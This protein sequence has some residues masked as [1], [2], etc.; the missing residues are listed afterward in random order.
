MR[1]T[2]LSALLLIPA[3]AWIDQQ[4]YERLEQD[5]EACDE[6]GLVYYPD[7]DGDGFGDATSPTTC[8][9]GAGYLTDGSDCDDGDPQVH[10]GAEEYCN[11]V[12]DDCDGQLDEDEAV[13]A[14]RWYQDQDG[15]GHAD[16]DTWTMAC[17]QP[18]GFL[19]SEDADDCDDHDATVNPEAD[20]ICGDG[21]DNDCDDAPEVGGCRLQGA[22]RWDAGQ[23]RLYAAVDEEGLGRAA[24][25]G[26]DLIGSHGT[27]L[28][29]GVQSWDGQATDGGGVLLFSGEGLA[30]AVPI[31]EHD[32]VLAGAT[33]GLAAGFRVAAMGEN[34]ADG[35]PWLAVTCAPDDGSLGAVLFLRGPFLE[36]SAD[37]EAEASGRMNASEALDELGASSSGGLDATGDGL[38]EL[39]LGAPG[40]NSGA[41]EAYLLHGPVVS[42]ESSDT[43]EGRIEGSEPGDRLGES[44]ALLPDV[45]GDGLADL[46]IGAST[47]GDAREG[48]V[49]LFLSPLAAG[50]Q[51]SDAEERYE[52]E[53]SGAMLHRVAAAGDVDGDGR[54]DMLLGAPGAGDNQ[55]GQVFLL[56]GATNPP[57]TLAHP[58]A[59]ILGSESG[60]ALGMALAGLEDFDGDGRGDILV[61]APLFDGDGMDAGEAFLF[62]GPVQGSLET[63]DADASVLGPGGSA[64]AGSLLGDAGD[65]DGDGLSDA[66]IGAPFGG[67]Q[68]IVLF[69]GQGW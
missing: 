35:S 9:Q 36:D 45:D 32:V 57:A 66:F 42:I 65:L 12:D 49:L 68:Q 67:F 16:P 47:A 1:T 14:V 48:E 13:D 30:G 7:E 20:E 22:K 53:Q 21:I 63:R 23:A 10:P 24:A 3:C 34:N 25:G 51:R 18:D 11:G 41:G 33:P 55:R 62:H 4:E 8:P 54:G 17:E 50:L 52:H 61:G 69:M 19:D 27:D 31:E 5:C 60:A 6:P 58:E 40:A 64:L 28:A 29:V 38:P 59:S 43:A 2:Y 26:Q 37:I 46:M 56:L 15:D 44:V 39:V